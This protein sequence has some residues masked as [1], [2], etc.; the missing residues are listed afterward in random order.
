MKL[1]RKGG[2]EGSGCRDLGVATT[3]SAGS[4]A[5]V[6]NAITFQCEEDSAQNRSGDC[7]VAE[8]QRMSECDKL[9]RATVCRRKRLSGSNIE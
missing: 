7:F 5:F 4:G 2:V 8:S 1:V 3:W 6:L 9:G